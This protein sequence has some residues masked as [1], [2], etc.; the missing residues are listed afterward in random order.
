[1]PYLTEFS[2]HERDKKKMSSIT[3]NYRLTHLILLNL[4]QEKVIKI[5]IHKIAN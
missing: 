3:H 1:M 5:D 2:Q 4:H